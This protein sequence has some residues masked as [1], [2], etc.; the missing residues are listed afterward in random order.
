[1]AIDKPAVH[2]VM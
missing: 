2:S 1:M